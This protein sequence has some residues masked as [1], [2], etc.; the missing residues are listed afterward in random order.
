MS[1]LLSSGLPAI[2][3]IITQN[4]SCQE[5]GRRGMGIRRRLYFGTV[6]W[7]WVFVGYLRGVYGSENSPGLAPWRRR[8]MSTLT[9]QIRRLPDPYWAPKAGMSGLIEVLCKDGDYE[10]VM[11]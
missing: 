2:F 8:G 5:G 10:K 7:F 3:R 4:R 11:I 1:D 6:Q 9:R